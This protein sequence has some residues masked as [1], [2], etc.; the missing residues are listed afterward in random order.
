M[1]KLYYRRR[2]REILGA[3]LK[4]SEG[5]GDE[6]VARAL[7]RR[8]LTVP[9]ALADYYAVAGRHPINREHNRLL[10]IARLQWH[11]DWL[12]FMEENQ[13]VVV[14]GMAR[15]DVGSSNPMVWQCSNAEPPQWFAEDYRL[16]QFLM[17]TWRWT[18]RGVEEKPD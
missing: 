5:L 15:A 10:P 3:P 12:V 16:S 17:A 11:D 13:N 4:E 18:R 14:W 6:A 9:R 7:E 2:F 1:F 8:R